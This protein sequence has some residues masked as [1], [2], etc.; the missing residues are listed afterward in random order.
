MSFIEKPFGLPVSTFPRPS[1]LSPQNLVEGPRLPV[2]NRPGNHPGLLNKFWIAN[3]VLILFFY[4][5]NLHKVKYF[6]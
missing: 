6:I 3:I 1:Y 4:Y 5:K 2:L